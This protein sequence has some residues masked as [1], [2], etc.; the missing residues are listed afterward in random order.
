MISTGHE[1]TKIRKNRSNI[2]LVVVGWSAFFG[3]SILSRRIYSLFGLVV[4]V[5]I[6]LPLAWDGITN[7]W[8][9]LVFF[10][11]RVWKSLAWGIG[12][13]VIS[14]LIG[15]SVLSDLAIPDNLGQQL[16]IGIPLWLLVI[17]P[18]QEFFFRGWMQSELTDKLGK[19]L[20]LL[21]ANVCF[22]AWHYLSPIVDLAPFPLES[23]AGLLST[24]A[25]GLV[26]GYAFQRSKN[27]IAPWLAHAI[28]G[29]LFLVFGAM[30]LLQVI[31]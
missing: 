3:L 7:D 26:Y 14:S 9:S 30:D 18:F 24:F 19:W 20:G 15:F 31:K 4:L 21:I 13:G 8:Q 1:R 29:I 12:A 17:S 10:K 2:V 23:W 28:S 16:L 6:G 25:A 11:R 27:V 5:G 22:T